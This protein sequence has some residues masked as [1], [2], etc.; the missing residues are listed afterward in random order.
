MCGLIGI[1]ARGPVN[2]ALCEGLTVLQHRGQDAAGLVTCEGNRLFLR[3]GN[4]L[5]RDVFSAEDMIQLRGR[6][7]I[8]HVRYPTAGGFSAAEAQPLYVR[9]PYGMVLAHNGQLTNSA[10]QRREI[11]RGRPDCL[12]TGSDSEVLLQVLADELRRADRTRLEPAQIFEAVRG[13]H[14]R[15]RGGYAVV[16]LIAGH[17]LLAFRDPHGI[18]PLVFG[19]RD[20]RGGKEYVFASE[21]VAIDILDFQRVRD[22]APGEA[23]F[24]SGDGAFHSRSWQGMSAAPSPCLFEFVYL[25][26]PDS[27][28]DGISVYEARLR[29]GEALARAIQKRWPEH[30]IDVVIPVP[31]TG[32]T[33]ALPLARRLGVEY[34]EGLVKNRYVPRTFIMPGQRVRKRSVRQKLNAIGAEFRGK[35]VLL[36]DDSLVRGTTSRQIVQMARNAGARKVYF[37]SAAPPVRYPNYYGIDIP[38]AEE[39]IAHGRGERE[40]CELVGADRLFYQGLDDLVQAVRQGNPSISRFDASCFDGVYMTGDRGPGGGPTADAGAPLAVAGDGA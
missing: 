38:S 21:S 39:L 33:A 26:R 4:G 32:R 40:I 14:R 36:V 20:S 18:R 16:A 15:C 9:L 3:K 34:R 2:Q 17:G 24:V 22:L 13:V 1:V 5:V 28:I 19:C 31:E 30:D 23:V 25:A 35:N 6:Q 12:R 27:V 29:M 7:G 11:S 37:A 8:G 10:E